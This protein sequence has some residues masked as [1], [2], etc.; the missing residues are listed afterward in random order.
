MND[1]RENAL[2]CES[3]L[4][5]YLI[6]LNEEEYLSFSFTG[7]EIWMEVLCKCDLWKILVFNSNS[8][9]IQWS[10]ST[11]REQLAG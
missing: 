1:R 3:L 9:F 4:K 10:L 2:S 11:W 8:A 6:V 7:H 5:L